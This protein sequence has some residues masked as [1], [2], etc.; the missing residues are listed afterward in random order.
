MLFHIIRSGNNISW[1]RPLS[2]ELF[3]KLLSVYSRI[4]SHT[5]E[6]NISISEC[7]WGYRQ[8][9]NMGIVSY[10]SSCPLLGLVKV[11]V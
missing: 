11:A 6:K 5:L 7:S 2:H 3:K 8:H 1:S 9:I 10:V 4:L